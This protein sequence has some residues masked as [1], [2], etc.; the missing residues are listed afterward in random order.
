MQKLIIGLLLLI[1]STSFGIDV[2]NMYRLKNT[3]GINAN[4]SIQTDP[5]KIKN[6][7]RAI[8]DFSDN[9]G[10]AVGR[11]VDSASDLGSAVVNSDGNFGKTADKYQDKTA[12]REALSQLNA[13][14]L[15]LIKNPDKYD[16][17]S[18]QYVADKFNKAYSEI[19]GLDHA[20]AVLFDDAK[21]ENE[22]GVTVK[23]SKTTAFYDPAKNEIYLEADKI[24]KDNK[25]AHALGH[26]AKRQDM[27]QK[28]SKEDDQTAIAF[29]AGL[30]TKKA[31][32]REL[33]YKKVGNSTKP[34]Y[35]RTN[36]DNKALTQGSQQASQVENVQ[37]WVETG[38]DALNVSMG[39]A[40]GANNLKEGKYGAAALD[41][42][43]LAWDGLTTVIPGLPGGAGSAIKAWRAKKAAKKLL[44]TRQKVIKSNSIK[45]TKR[46]KIVQAEL[47]QEHGVGNV[48]QQ[49]TILD[50]NGKKLV[51]GRTGQGRRLDH[52]VLDQQG[53]AIKRVETT[54]LTAEKRTQL[55]K[56]KSILRS[57]DAYV[58]HPET[59][60][61]IK[62]ND[63]ILEVRR[64]E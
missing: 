20:E 60:K 35:V 24:Q 27:N 64:K 38:W 49:R 32:E 13:E 51:D 18:Q 4:V 55:R 7:L 21:L 2:Q 52:V 23:A 12:R 57:N 43:G 1:C 62:I 37:P 22:Q 6:N 15:D 28:D 54:S 16:L 10:V 46:E 40:S 45:G 44:S 61:L 5:Q 36:A 53:K 3:G 34:T 9:A 26:E 25:M 29:E 8:R 50:K 47:E 19:R 48:L 17:V 63:S 58:K 39:V 14:E 56:E 33:K 42:V 59:G 30:H 11:T 31:F 41:G